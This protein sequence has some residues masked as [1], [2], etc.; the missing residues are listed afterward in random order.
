MSSIVTGRI[1]PIIA[2]VITA[3]CLGTAAVPFMASAAPAAV[4]SASASHISASPNEQPW[5]GP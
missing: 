4:G 2:A 1:K 5:P 3:A